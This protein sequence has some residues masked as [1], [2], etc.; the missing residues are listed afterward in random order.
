MFE[1]KPDSVDLTVF[2]TATETA[3]MRVAAMAGKQRL[4]KSFFADRTQN[5]KWDEKA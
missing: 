1:V 3:V 5:L 2:K 4:V